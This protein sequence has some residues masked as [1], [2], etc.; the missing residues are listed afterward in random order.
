MKYRIEDIMEADFGCEERQP[1][2]QLLCCLALSQAGEKTVS[3]LI[4]RN[5]PDAL[6]DELCLVKGQ[7]ISDKEL[8][9]MM[10]GRKP[11][12]WDDLD[13]RNTY[14]TDIGPVCMS[15]AEYRMYM[16]RKEERK[17][18]QPQTESASAADR[19]SFDLA[20]KPAFS[21]SFDLADKP[22][23]S[24]A[25][26]STPGPVERIDG[27]DISTHCELSIRKTSEKDL[28]EVMS[29]YDHA[30]RFMKE[31]GNPRQWGDNWPPVD[32]IRED[33]RR[34]KSYI[35]EKDGEILGTFFYSCGENAEPTYLDIDGRF[36]GSPVYGV[37][38]RIAVSGNGH[39]VG[40]FCIN[41]AFQ[42]CKNL[43]MD[44]HPDNKVMQHTL[45]RNGFKYCGIVHVAED[46]DP[47]YAYEKY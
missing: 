12:G 36:T 30:R 37:V 11:E 18:F 46:N 10:A 2:Q 21:S 24:Q 16:D 32:L 22:A 29:I 42:Q 47:R 25:D 7:I 9:A 8:E 4:Y 35:C 23:F 26:E 6:A 5:M 34:G 41:W 17:Y 27:A 44:T 39:G 15:S 38:H 28:P 19:P 20:V 1:D 43:R 45:L 33:I 40:S 31:H 14:A 13:H 3:S